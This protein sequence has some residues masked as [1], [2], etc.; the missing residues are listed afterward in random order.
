LNRERETAVRS[1]VAQLPDDMRAVIALCEFEDFSAEEASAVLNMNVKAV[2]N[3]LY[4]ARER[5]RETLKN[6]L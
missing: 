5:L 3:R 1:A 6:W 4:R 2:Q